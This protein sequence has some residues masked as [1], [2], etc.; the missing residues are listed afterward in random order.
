MFAV[1]ASVSSLGDD[2]A[3]Q[4][5]LVTDLRKLLS[6][7]TGN[8][9]SE[10]KRLEEL[11]IRRDEEHAEATHTIEVLHE[12]MEHSKT[13][14]QSCQSDHADVRGTSEHMHRVCCMSQQVPLCCGQMANCRQSQSSQVNKK[15]H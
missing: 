6:E 3:A 12:K 8:L 7:S 15:G 1:Q 5:N 11:T 9:Q 4:K 10:R 14:L 2:L 13:Q